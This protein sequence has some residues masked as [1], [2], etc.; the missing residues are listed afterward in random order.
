[1]CLV[2][3][4]CLVVTAALVAL[5]SLSRHSVFAAMCASIFFADKSATS[6]LAAFTCVFSDTKALSHSL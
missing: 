4:A 5:L 6:N 1:M 2:M 3:T